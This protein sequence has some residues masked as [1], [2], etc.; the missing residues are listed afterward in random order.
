MTALDW[1]IVGL[2]WVLMFAASLVTRRYVKGVADF[3]A[4][5]RGAGRYLICVAEGA[6]GMGLITV[7]AMFEQ[8]SRAGTAI[9]WWGNLAI[10]VGVM[11]TLSGFVIYRFR[12]TRALTLAQFFEVRYSRAFRVFAGLLAFVSGV[13]NYGIFPGVS[14]RFFVY[15]LGLPETLAIAGLAVP[16]FAI[17]MA[18]FLSLALAFV[19]LGGQLQILVTDCL[20]GALGGFLMLAVAG[21]M[22]SQ[23]SFEQM[24]EAVSAVPDNQSLINPFKTSEVKDFNIWYALIG[25]MGLVYTQ[26][27]WQGNQG[28]N[29]SAANPHEAKMG[30][31]LASWRG[32]AQG[33][34]LTILALGAYGFLHH[35]DFAARAAVV[36]SSL[37]RI[38]QPQIQ[39]QMR[40]PLALS[41]LL[42]AGI[43]GAFAAL[44]LLMMVNVDKSYLHSW[45][46]I[47]IQDVVMPFRRTALSPDAH[48]RLLRWAIAG[49]AVW[50]FCFSLV[51]RQTDYIL[52]FF[53][54]TGALYLGGAGSVII[55]GLYWKRGTTGAAWTAMILGSV[56]AVSGL[57]LQNVWPD[58]PING[59][60]TFF[61][62]MVVSIG[63]YAGVS[64]LT[65]RVPFDLERMLH[66]VDGPPRLPN[67]SWLELLLGVDR[68]FQRGDR[69]ISGSVFVWNGVMFA[70][71]LIITASNL[72]RIWP[73]RWWWNYN[74]VNLGLTAV[75]ASVT[76]VWFGCGGLRDL[77]R[78]FRL[79]ART[80]NNPL[81]DG[82][83]VAHQNAA[84]LPVPEAPSAEPTA[85]RPV[86]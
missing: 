84:E 69:I 82:T 62:A 56:L 21:G 10:P 49:V 23:V 5:G 26:M 38:D 14:A 80:K 35:P 46:S 17:L 83:V 58:F 45:G 32:Y 81:D 42:P 3:L 52:M 40:V 25:L 86:G 37:G 39:E 2:P 33:L 65:C 6:A 77:F 78:L 41:M 73:D 13:V 43:K 70:A 27:A 57:V 79:L 36:M 11:L 19:L 16:T 67:R 74:L 4:A 76:V 59:Q 30:R 75:I 64:L 66:R 18:F 22:L 29:S 54:V 60:V 50:G 63:S 1:A 24:F 55:G 85:S 71:F 61:L 51:F 7:I 28:F 47:F 31:V 20:A 8:Y 53:A 12:E 68:E 15:Y 34:M 44:M 9:L 48:L 72:W